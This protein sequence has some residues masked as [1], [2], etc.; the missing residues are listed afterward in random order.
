VVHGQQRARGVGVSP[1]RI[2]GADANGVECQDLTRA[3]T[4]G[5]EKVPGARLAS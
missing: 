4:G 5:G 1:T 3:I 2:S